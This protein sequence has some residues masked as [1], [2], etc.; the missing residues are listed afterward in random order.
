M[1]FSP[2]PKEMMQFDEYFSNELVQPLPIEQRYCFQMG[3]STREEWN[4]IDGSWEGK[5]VSHLTDP[6]GG[7]MRRKIYL[8]S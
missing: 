2:L 5:K 4:E 1:L 8:P 7:S 6:M 3:G